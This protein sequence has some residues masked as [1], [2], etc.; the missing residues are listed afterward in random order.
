MLAS[1]VPVSNFP[2]IL[3]A[4]ATALSLNQCL[5]RCTIRESFQIVERDAKPNGTLY[6][7]KANIETGG[8]ASHAAECRCYGDRLN[9][10]NYHG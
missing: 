8:L 2:V 6:S 5:Q 1:V 9:H 10:G 4:D 3:K 7:L